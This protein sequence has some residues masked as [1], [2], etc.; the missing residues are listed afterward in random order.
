[1]QREFPNAPVVGVGAVVIDKDLVLLVRRGREPLK[2][3]WSLPG[4]ALELGERLEQGIVREVKE[5]TGLTVEPMEIIEVFD[6]ITREG[7]TARVRFHY[8]LVDY[9]CRVTS[10][11]LCAA[12]DVTE[13]RWVTREELDRNDDLAILPFTR[14]VIEKGF[15]AAKGS[16]VTLPVVHS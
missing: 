8:V 9:R 7:D 4:G 5:E 1:M 16:P 10:G 15:L 2:G 6:H 12:S 13:A 14:S 11:N 3:Q